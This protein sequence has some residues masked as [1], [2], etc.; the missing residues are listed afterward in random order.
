MLNQVG[1]SLN[2]I[3]IL[4][5]RDLKFNIKNTQRLKFLDKIEIKNLD[6]KYQKIYS[7]KIKYG[8]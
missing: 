5:L 3:N 8:Y 6:F 7:K 4:K 2:I 1:P